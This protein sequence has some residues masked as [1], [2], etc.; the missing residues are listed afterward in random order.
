MLS[1]RNENT[2]Q[3]RETF[4]ICN[5]PSVHQMQ[6]ALA[7]LVFRNDTAVSKPSERLDIRLQL[8]GYLSLGGAVGDGLMQSLVV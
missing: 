4:P 2:G 6:Y 5:R 8:T 3:V 7:V 1:K